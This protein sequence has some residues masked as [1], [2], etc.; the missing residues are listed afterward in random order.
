M[1]MVKS[2]IL[3]L[4]LA[5]SGCS[6]LLNEPGKTE[7]GIDGLS[8]TG[9][10]VSAVPGLIEATNPAL[11]EHARLPKDK[12]GVCSAK[13][14]SVIAP[15]TLYRIFDAS[16]PKSKFGG[17][18]SLKPPSGTKEDYRSAN[19]I[20][21]EWSAL[22]RVV[23][24]EIRPGTQVVIGTTQSAQCEDGSKYPQTSVNQVFVPN[25]GRVGIIHIG[26]CSD[27]APWP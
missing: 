25:D 9:Y 27:E 24:C 13:V 18:W 3:T 2:A 7:V 8:C 16:N 17:W 21:R 1:Y 11:V 4:A 12:G 19:A 6:S 20:C 15:V 14:F 26:A 22:D 23:S 10:V 5:I